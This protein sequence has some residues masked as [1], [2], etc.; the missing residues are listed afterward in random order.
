M[1]VWNSTQNEE[2]WKESIFIEIQRDVYLS[3]ILFKKKRRKDREK[4]KNHLQANNILFTLFIKILKNT[5]KSFL[6]HKM[7]S[8]HQDH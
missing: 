8:P 5:R 3:L 1:G 7:K 6:P 4:E 2:P